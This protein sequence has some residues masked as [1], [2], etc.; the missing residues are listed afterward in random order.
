VKSLFFGLFVS[1]FAS[2][3][4][5]IPVESYVDQ[6]KNIPISYEASGTICEQVARL[7]VMKQYP[8]NQFETVTGIAYGDSQR[9]IGELDVIVFNRTTNMVVII[10]EVK[11]WKDLAAAHTKAL[12][13]RTRFLNSMRSSKAF[14]L[15]SPT[16]AYSKQQFMA[17]D[18]QFITISQAGGL[19]YGFTYAL[20]HSLN[21]LMSLRTLMLRCQS[22][23]LCARP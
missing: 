17:P 23:N 19:D 12:A 15:F 22:D 8:D 11:C 2:L 13:Q 10:A 5:A 18:L 7:E 21:E 3:S 14:K 6:L 4:Y 16:Q 20:E 9:T 1:L